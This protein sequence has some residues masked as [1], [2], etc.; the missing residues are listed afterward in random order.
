MYETVVGRRDA[1]N[2]MK[3]DKPPFLEAITKGKDR[4]PGGKAWSLRL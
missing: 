4:G 1:E 3:E 2:A